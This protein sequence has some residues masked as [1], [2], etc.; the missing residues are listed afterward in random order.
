MTRFMASVVNIEREHPLVVLPW[1]INSRIAPNQ[2]QRTSILLGPTS[3]S[4]TTS[5][6]F[7]QSLDSE[8]GIGGHMR[9]A[10]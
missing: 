2:V 1:S 9:A 10:R 3:P 7:R 8:A 6:A 4:T 5:L